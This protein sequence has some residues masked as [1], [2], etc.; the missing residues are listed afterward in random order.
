MTLLSV[1]INGALHGFFACSCGVLQGDPFSPLLFCLAEEVISR[2]ILQLVSNRKLDLISGPKK[3]T[4]PSHIL[5]ADDVLI[6][7]KE[8]ISNL[9]YLIT[10]FK[11]YA[12]VSGQHANYGKSYIF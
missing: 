11:E 3:I 10:A 6:F 12:F 8:K 1:N 9:K 4:V 2:K 5:F 7:C